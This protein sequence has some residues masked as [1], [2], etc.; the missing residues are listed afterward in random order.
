MSV[1]DNEEIDLKKLIQTYVVEDVKVGECIQNTMINTKRF[2]NR[3]YSYMQKLFQEEQL[4]IMREREAMARK[5]QQEN[6]ATGGGLFSRL[7]AGANKQPEQPKPQE[8]RNRV[9]EVN[10]YD[11]E[12]ETNNYLISTNSSKPKQEDAKLIDFGDDEHKTPHPP[13]EKEVPMKLEEKDFGDDE[14][15][16]RSETE[17]VAE[18]CDENPDLFKSGPRGR[19]DSLNSTSTNVLYSYKDLNDFVNIDELH[20]FLYKCGAMLV[21]QSSSKMEEWID[22]M[23]KTLAEYYVYC[24]ILYKQA[25]DVEIL[26]D[27]MS[28]KLQRVKYKLDQVTNEK[29]SPK[30]AKL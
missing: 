28:T 1:L 23:Q 9:R 15:T 3:Q 7:F 2:L 6:K 26:K 19:S 14:E 29:V 10:Y 11:D 16:K 27:F 25:K 13:Q 4:R 30:K 5:Q 20:K 12:D 8:P 18:A 21:S 22:W 17:T 24:Q